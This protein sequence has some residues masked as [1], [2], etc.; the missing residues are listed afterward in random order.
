MKRIAAS[1]NVFDEK[2]FNIQRDESVEVAHTVVLRSNFGQDW[3]CV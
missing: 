1:M 3:R 2:V